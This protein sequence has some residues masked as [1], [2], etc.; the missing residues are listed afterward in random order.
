MPP[1]NRREPDPALAP[2]PEEGQDYY[3]LRVAQAQLEAA[4]R[5][6]LLDKEAIKRAKAEFKN[7]LLET[8][9]SAESFDPKEE[10]VMAAILAAAQARNDTAAQLMLLPRSDRKLFQAPSN[11][12]QMPDEEVLINGVHIPVPRGKLL[13]APSLVWQLLDSAQ[14]S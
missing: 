9:F 13:S 12:K 2:D 10:P 11:E 14:I 1:R 6:P 7:V 5:D 8:N 3:A 4:Q